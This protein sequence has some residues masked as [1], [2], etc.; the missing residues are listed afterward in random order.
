MKNKCLSAFYQLAMK[1]QLEISV[2]AVLHVLT[3]LPGNRPVLNKSK[4]NHRYANIFQHSA[5]AKSSDSKC[6]FPDNAE[7]MQL[8]VA[9]ARIRKRGEDGGGFSMGRH[10]VGGRRPGHGLC[11][12]RAT[13]HQHFHAFSCIISSDSLRC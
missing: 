2:I 6:K 1:L 5:S 10:Q 12:P 7:P 9:L 11:G 8:M 3:P 4:A 13:P